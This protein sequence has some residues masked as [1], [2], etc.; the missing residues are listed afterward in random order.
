[1]K[2]FQDFWSNGVSRQWLTDHLPNISANSLQ[3]AA[4]LLLHSATL[5]SLISVMLAWTDKPPMLDMVILVWS[6]LIAMFAQAMVLRNQTL[7]ILIS[8]GFMFQSI[9]LALIF[10]R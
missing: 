6:G 1:M 7:A 4:V 10:F 2:S 3:I 8:A 9:L 5:P